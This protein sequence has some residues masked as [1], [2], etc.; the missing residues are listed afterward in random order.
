MDNFFKE[1]ISGQQQLDE[2]IRNSRF[3]RKVK[4]DKKMKTNRIKQDGSKVEITLNQREYYSQS[5]IVAFNL[6]SYSKLIP[7]HDG[8]KTII[9]TYF[10]RFWGP[11]FDWKEKSK[12]DEKRIRRSAG[13]V[14]Y[15]YIVL[16]SYCWGK[17][18]TWISL[19]TLADN[20]SVKK[21]AVRRYLEELEE[22]GF[23]IRFWRES[24]I[25]GNIEEESMLIKVRQTI[26]FLTKEKLEL[27]PDNL[28]K[29]HDNFLKYI[30]LE[31][32]KEFHDSYNY[33]KVYEELRHKAIEV[34]EP[35]RDN[36]TP[37]KQLFEQITDKDRMIW[38]R[39]KERLKY[40]MAES[41]IRHWFTGAILHHRDRVIT[42]YVKDDYFKQHIEDNFMQ[43]LYTVMN[44]LMIEADQIVIE[45]YES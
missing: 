41:S 27:L 45:N 15:T 8:Y 18:Y 21:N 40:Y 1:M 24:E 44:D 38:N 28:K 35:E 16:K 5:D 39:I 31:S 12:G 30:R 37:F 25:D 2:K 14:A 17:D 6:E 33:T 13:M 11:V 32:E 9:N 19:Q 42:I 34:K 29:E 26:P 43:I 7:D 10:I 20:L 23:I 36:L 4:T 22:E 3:Y